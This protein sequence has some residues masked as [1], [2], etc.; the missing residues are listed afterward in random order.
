MSNQPRILVVDDDPD[1]AQLLSDYLGLH[2][3]QV[4]AVQDEPQLQS[5]VTTFVPDL[6][7]LDQR[8]GHVS[9]TDVLRG[10][11]AISDVPVIIVTGTSETMDRIV[12]LEIGADDE[13]EKT[14]TPRE[15]LARIRSVLRRRRREHEVPAEPARPSWHLDGERR[16][17]RRPGGAVCSLTNAEFETLQILHAAKGNPVSRAE[18]CREVFGRPFRVGDRA[19]DTIV[20]NLRRKIEPDASDFVS[21]QA[22]R[23][24]GY[25][26]VGF[27]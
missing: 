10:L 23:T 22:V 7:L 13:M 11:R 27:P 6:V 20:K 25:V 21:I 5:A 26:F 4:L 12:N 3:C 19:V 14:V 8:L 15:M 17:L 2:G 1:F 18:L 24:F 9:G 16:V